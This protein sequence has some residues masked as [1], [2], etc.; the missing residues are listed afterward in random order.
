MNVIKLLG[1][2]VQVNTGSGTSVPNIGGIGA[3]Y[4]LLQ[5]DHS[6]GQAHVVEVRTGA[7]V[8]TGSLHL[9]PHNPIIVQKNRT[10]LVYCSSADVYATSV[11]YQ[12]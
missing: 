7:G 3:Q 8:T 11:V 5:H 12:G 6:G 9:A 4:V 1:E 10:D 2:A